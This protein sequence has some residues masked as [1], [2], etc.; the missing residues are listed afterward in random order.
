M[1][2]TLALLAELRELLAGGDRVAFAR[3]TERISRSL[4]RGAYRHD[5]SVWKAEEGGQQDAP[6]V[7]AHLAQNGQHRPYFEVLVVRDGLTPEQAQRRRDEIRKVRRPE[8]PFIYEVVHVPSFEDAV[9]A[10]ICNF[11]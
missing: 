7:P 8:D 2:P 3:L 5:P 9:L 1:M 10:T 4:L 6:A 11:N